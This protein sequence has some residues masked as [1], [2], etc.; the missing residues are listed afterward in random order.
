[1]RRPFAIPLLCGLALVAAARPSWADVAL[2]HLFSDHM[3]LQR[4]MKVPVW[5]TADPG[6]RV[7]VTLGGREAATVAG[8]DGRWKVILED[9]PAGGPSELKVAGKNAITIRDVLVGEVWFC[10]GQSNMDF[11][12]A[13]TEKRYFAGVAD[14][15]REIAAADYPQIRMFTAEWTLRD[16]PQ[17]DVEGRWSVCSPATVGDFSAVAYVFGRQLHKALGV[18]VGLINCSYGASTAQAWTSRQ[19]LEADPE[20]DALL[21]A[22]EAACKAYTPELAR[23]DEEA[24]AKWRQAAEKAW[25]EGKAAP[26]APRLKNPHQD[27]H[28]PCVLFN[29]MVAPVVPYGIRGAIWYQ[30]E[31]NTDVPERYEKLQATLIRDWRKLWGEGDF[32]FLFVQLPNYRAPAAEP[33]AASRLAAMREAQANTLSLP[34]TGM[35]VTID[36]GEEKDIHPRNKQDVGRRLALIA[37]AQVYRRDVV[38]SGPVFESASFQGHSAR[39]RFGHTE[40][41]LSARGGTLSGFAVAGEDRK[42]AW[43]DARIDGDTV[44]VS[45]PQVEAPVI[46]RYAWADNPPATLVNGAG[47][48]ARPF[49]TDVPDPK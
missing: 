2:N 49:R 39:V 8:E 32:P 4:E 41:G 37:E 13:K 10:S 40:G 30:G 22:Y 24:Q 29:G 48:P 27:Q 19:S 16:E 28:N 18:P 23:K 3:V 6:E 14:A 26:R 17:A 12:V 9:L 15:E 20:L 45:S 31:S 21:V 43:A 1:M 35:A 44:V 47:L 36:V 7:V 38:A 25:A 42:F 46:V 11:T 5:G 34:N 33:P